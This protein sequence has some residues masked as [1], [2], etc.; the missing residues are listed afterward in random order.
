MIVWK[1]LHND[2]SGAKVGAGVAEVEGDGD[3]EEG[4]VGNEITNIFIRLVCIPVWITILLAALGESFGG[5]MKKNPLM[6]FL[7]LN[8]STLEHVNQ[9][10]L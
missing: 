6:V 10:I 5:G 4:G 2:V 7:Q 1:C 3:V 8:K 9:G